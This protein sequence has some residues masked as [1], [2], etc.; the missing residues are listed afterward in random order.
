MKKSVSGHLPKDRPLKKN[1][2]FACGPDNPEGMRLKFHLDESGKHF[3]CNFR[4]GK[5]YTGPP[6]HCH[7]GIIATILDDAMGKLNK[8]RDVL[9]M[10]AK[11]TVEYL[12]PV[13][14]YKALQVESH[15]ISRRGRR[16]THMAQITDEKGTVLARSRGVFV[17]IDPQRVFGR[18]L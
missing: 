11:M 2:C 16:L 4:L 17:I 7:G 8:L 1:F 10:T 15:E 14:L 3:I 5:R 6:R 18:K 12:R 9:A 13:P